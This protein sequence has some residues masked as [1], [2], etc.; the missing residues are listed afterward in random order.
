MIEN[1]LPGVFGERL[2]ERLGKRSDERSV[3]RS[4]LRLAE[5]LNERFGH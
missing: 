2:D 1:M 5:W 3:E 4:G